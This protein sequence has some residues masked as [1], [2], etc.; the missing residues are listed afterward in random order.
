MRRP[1]EGRLLAGT[2]ALLDRASPDTS[3]TLSVGS[4]VYSLADGGVTLVQRRVPTSAIGDQSLAAVLDDAVEAGL[5]ERLGTVETVLDRS[6]REY[7]VRE[8][9]A[10]V[11]LKLTDESRL[12]VC[13]DDDGLVLRE[14]W[15]LRG[16]LVLERRAVELDESPTQRALSAAL[17]ADGEAGAVPSPASVRAVERLDCFLGEPD[18]PAGLRQMGRYESAA[19]DQVVG[20]LQSCAWVMSGR[21]HFVVVEAGTGRIRLEDGLR[22]IATPGL[23]DGAVY[24]GWTGSEVRIAIDERR[25]VRVTSSAPAPWLEEYAAT[26]RLAD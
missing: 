17:Q 19:L 7:V 8:P 9:G 26:L 14:R 5:A 3:G 23:G 12:G 2:S 15:E 4:D 16:E 20:P 24:I 22:R 1:F 25:W 6:C 18:V 10:A 11:L 13:I 21:G